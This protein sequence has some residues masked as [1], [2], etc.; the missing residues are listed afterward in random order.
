M[1]PDPD[2]QVAHFQQV[3][4]KKTKMELLSIKSKATNLE[5]PEHIAATLLLADMEDLES[6][7][8]HKEIIGWAKAAFVAGAISA[9]IGV[10]ELLH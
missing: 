8:R 1:K 10:I 2:P 7:N 9:L 6:N 5:S 4:A 3:Y